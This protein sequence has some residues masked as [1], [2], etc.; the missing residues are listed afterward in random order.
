[1]DSAGERR[2]GQGG[3]SPAVDMDT[4]FFMYSLKN[5]SLRTQQP[6]PDARIILVDG[7]GHGA[8]AIRHPSGG[9]GPLR[10]LPQVF[11]EKMLG[12]LVDNR[13]DVRLALEQGD[14]RRPVLPQHIRAPRM[15]GGGLAVIEEG[16]VKPVGLDGGGIQAYSRSIRRVSAVV[17]RL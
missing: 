2:V 14:E 6:P 10:G 11:K 7:L 16:H 15:G 9:V 8:P 3:V 12:P 4:A 1:M 13:G 17:K 5:T